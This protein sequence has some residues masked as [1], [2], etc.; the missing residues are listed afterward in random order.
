MAAC[1]EPG[2]RLGIS[3]CREGSGVDGFDFSDAVRRRAE[4]EII[5]DLGNVAAGFRASAGIGGGMFLWRSGIMW[6]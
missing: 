5:F 6:G 3:S 4:S 2:R 1:H